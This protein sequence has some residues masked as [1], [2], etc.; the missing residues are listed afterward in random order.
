MCDYSLGV[1]DRGVEK[2]IAQGMAQGIEN[3]KLADIM[4]IMKNLG[5]SLDKALE[6]LNVP[7]S[8]YAKYEELLK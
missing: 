4:S 1:Y 7:K 3:A 5:M 8:D 6:A 2:G